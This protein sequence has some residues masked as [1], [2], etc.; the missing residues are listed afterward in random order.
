MPF[1]S[2]S[3]KTAEFSLHLIKSNEQAADHLSL[4]KRVSGQPRN[5]Q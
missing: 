3:L 2:K 4:I 1:I 5:P